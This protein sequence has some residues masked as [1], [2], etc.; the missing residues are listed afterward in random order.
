MA[1]A[2]FSPRRRGQTANQSEGRAARQWVEEHYTRH[3]DLAIEDGR[4]PEDNVDFECT[5]RTGISAVIPVSSLV[6]IYRLKDEEDDAP[7]EE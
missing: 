7:E 4:V 1:T 2:T 3:R 6:C 5:V